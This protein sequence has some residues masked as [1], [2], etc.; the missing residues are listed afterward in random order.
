MFLLA[1]P[2]DNNIP[3]SWFEMES[4]IFCTGFQPI[5]P[6]E[7]DS[8]CDSWPLS[9]KALFDQICITEIRQFGSIKWPWSADISHKIVDGIS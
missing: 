2:H 6:T 7:M 8:L 4:W 1:K 3:Y 5:R 9:S